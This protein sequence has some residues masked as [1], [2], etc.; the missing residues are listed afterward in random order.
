MDSKQHDSNRVGDIENKENDN[1]HTRGG[2]QSA[3]FENKGEQITQ[4]VQALEALTPEARNAL[5][6]ALGLGG[7]V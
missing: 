6:Q 4:I 1:T 5:L 3:P 2:P 7:G